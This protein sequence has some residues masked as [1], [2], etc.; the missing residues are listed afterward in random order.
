MGGVKWAVWAAAVEMGGSLGVE[1]GLGRSVCPDGRKGDIAFFEV[2]R[3]EQRVEL[4]AVGDPLAVETA[5]SVV[6][7]RDTVR[8]GSFQDS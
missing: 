2:L 3:V 1:V 4:V 6:R 5:S 8:P 7:C